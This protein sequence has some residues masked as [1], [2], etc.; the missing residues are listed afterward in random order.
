M[1]RYLKEPLLH[2]IVLGA[3]LFGIYEILNRDAGF[4]DNEIIITQG[5]IEHL[6]N[7]FSRTWQ[8][9][10]TEQE[11][12]RLIDNYIQE[13]VLYREGIRMGLDQDDTIIRRRVKQ[14]VEFIANNIMEQYEPSD[15]ELQSYL[16]DNS[17]DFVTE[18]YFTFIQIYLNKEK[19][20]KSTSM[21]AKNILSQLKE[22][23]SHSN[24]YE[25]GDP[26]MLEQYYSD[27]SLSFI[28][29]TFGKQFAEQLRNISPGKWSGPISST[30]GLHL[31]RIDI[32]TD[33]R[34]PELQ[35]IRDVVKREWENKQQN[36]LYEKYYAEL[37]KNY[38]IRIEGSENA[39]E[40]NAVKSLQAAE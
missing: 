23:K 36:L 28:E 37:L 9:P 38:E 8:R 20:G 22:D 19:R 5:K 24:S 29:R 31:V 26:S 14:K 7:V 11:L 25:L 4:D 21:E 17:E 6:A 39:S 33:S 13:E 2:F 34:L 32:K 27:I 12:Q 10:P 1:Y 40:R 16:L 15:M 30:Y 35:E 18:E 3:V